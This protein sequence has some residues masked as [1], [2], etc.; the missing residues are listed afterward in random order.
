[1]YVIFTF[2]FPL[3]KKEVFKGNLFC[4]VKKK[5]HISLKPWDFFLTKIPWHSI[6]IFSF[7][8]NMFKLMKTYP[9]KL[10]MTN[11]DELLKHANIAQAQVVSQKLMD[12]MH[13]SSERESLRSWFPTGR[14]SD[15]V[16]CKAEIEGINWTVKHRKR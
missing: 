2:L 16:S 12:R 5:I 3:L 15:T 8:T 7:M 14:W 1:M 4:Y 13:P 10:T 6:V 9:T 11:L